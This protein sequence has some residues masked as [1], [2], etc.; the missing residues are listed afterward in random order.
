MTDSTGKAGK[1][2][3][4]HHFHP[5]G[6]APSIS[7]SFIP[8]HTISHTEILRRQ[9]IRER[10]PNESDHKPVNSIPSPSPSSLALT[11]EADVVADEDED[12]A[13]ET[14]EARGEE[15]ARTAE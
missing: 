14:D 9:P 11:C 7:S 6:P 1:R 2:S 4:S 13:D 12:E 15:E 3:F 5:H 8:P 10:I